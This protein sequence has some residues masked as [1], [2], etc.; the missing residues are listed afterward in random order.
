MKHL[1]YGGQRWKNLKIG[2]MVRE[3][4]DQNWWSKMV[5]IVRKIVKIVRE[6]IPKSS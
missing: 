2:K 5:K 4:T 1:G 3:G 6:N